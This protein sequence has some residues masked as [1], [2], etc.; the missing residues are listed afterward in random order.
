MRHK[1]DLMNITDWCVAILDRKYAW[2][3]DDLSRRI[4]AYYKREIEFARHG[5]PKEIVDG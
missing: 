3:D 4:I 2:L 5:Y 1:P